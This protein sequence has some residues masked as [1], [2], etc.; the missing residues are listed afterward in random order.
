[1]SASGSSEEEI[2]ATFEVKG[3]DPPTPSIWRLSGDPM[4]FNSS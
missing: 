1:M 4:I 2:I 3:S